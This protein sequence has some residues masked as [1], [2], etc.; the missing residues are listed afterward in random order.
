MNMTITKFRAI[1]PLPRTWLLL[2]LGLAAVVI[3]WGSLELDTTAVLLMSAGA[4]AAAALS[5]WFGVEARAARTRRYATFAV[6]ASLAIVGAAQVTYYLMADAGHVQA[7][8]PVTTIVAIMPVV[9]FGLAL[10]LANQVTADIRTIAA[11]M[12]T[13][14]TVNSHDVHAFLSKSWSGRPAWSGRV[15]ILTMNADL[16]KHRV[17]T[18]FGHDD[19]A[20]TW[21]SSR[22]CHL[23]KHQTCLGRWSSC[24]S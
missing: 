19:H 23:L 14:L 20:D 2:V 11:T 7:S 16:R 15:V 12:E 10:T 17:S 1:W 18:G 13:L 4:C 24:P 8:W 6:F 3:V 22:D 5:M 9:L 21:T